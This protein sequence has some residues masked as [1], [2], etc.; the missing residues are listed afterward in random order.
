MNKQMKTLDI[1]EHVCKEGKFLLI[2][3][4]TGVSRVLVKTK[5]WQPV[6][7]I[8]ALK[9]VKLGDTVLDVGASCG[10]LT[11]PFAKAVGNEGIVHAFE[12]QRVVFQQ[13]CANIILNGLPNV[14]A[15]NVGISDSNRIAKFRY[16]DR[17]SYTYFETM[18]FG[19]YIISD[20]E[21]IGDDVEIRTLDSFKIPNVAF[22]KIDIE[23]H[24][25]QSLH[26][27]IETIK[28]CKPA[29]ILEANN[30]TPEQKKIGGKG[31]L[32]HQF[33]DKFGYVRTPLLGKL[34]RA[35]NFLFVPRG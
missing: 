8:P 15:H 25:L 27:A 34:G 5:Q 16:K 29:I 23:N 22:I 28:R 31:G 6:V 11:I 12:P 19:R 17:D 4:D 21:E 33:L 30:I 10:P 20:D 35:K 7:L 26:G 1:Q 2:K 14:H 9:Y 3:N 18:S 24:E 32:I 13:L